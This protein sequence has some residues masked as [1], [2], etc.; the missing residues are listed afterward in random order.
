M[1]KAVVDY[2]RVD[3]TRVQVYRD[4]WD[5]L[6]KTF[7]NVQCSGLD[8]ALWYYSR[9]HYSRW[10]VRVPLFDAFLKTVKSG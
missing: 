4:D 2:C 7:E 9:W 8:P 1:D 10:Y 5:R 3:Y 6:L